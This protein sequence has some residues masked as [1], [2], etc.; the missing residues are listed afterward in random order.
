ML[1]KY[2]KIQDKLFHILLGQDMYDVLIPK[3]DVR[4]NGQEEP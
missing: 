1:S 3:G 2:H 4:L